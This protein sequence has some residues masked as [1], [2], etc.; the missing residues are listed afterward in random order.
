MAPFEKAIAERNTSAMV[1]IL[2]E[3]TTWSPHEVPAARQRVREQL[4][5]YSFA[6]ALDPAPMQELFL[7]HTK[8]LQN[9]CAGA[10]HRGD[11]DHFQLHKSAD[12]L[13]QDIEVQESL[14]FRDTSHAQYGEAEEFNAIVLDFLGKL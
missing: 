2:M 12:K 6:Y 11:E 5:E 1:D 14:D 8:D 10:D 3:D 4:S 7:Q 13:A 9:S